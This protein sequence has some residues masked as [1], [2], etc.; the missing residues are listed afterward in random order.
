[1]KMTFYVF[2]DDDDGNRS[3]SSSTEMEIDK[4]KLAFISLYLL[5]LLTLF[6]FFV[7]NASLLII[8]FNTTSIPLSTLRAGIRR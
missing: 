6:A 1:M 4:Q 8:V 5:T 7:G 2:N 3:S